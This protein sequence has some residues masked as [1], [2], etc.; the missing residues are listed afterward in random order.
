[1]FVGLVSSKGYNGAL[2]KSPHNFV[3]KN[4]SQIEVTWNSDTI[5]HRSIPFS[6]KPATGA[7]IDDYLQAVRYLRVT[8]G[9]QILGN[10]INRFNYTNGMEICLFNTWLQFN[11]VTLEILESACFCMQ[12]MS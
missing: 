2:N 6:F 8:A 9:N 1:M 10:G 7:G 11:P 3:H 5:Q 4:I 12:E